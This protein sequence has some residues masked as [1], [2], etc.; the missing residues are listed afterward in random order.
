MEGRWLMTDGLARVNTK[1]WT[2]FQR[3]VLWS[4][5]LALAAIGV[6]CHLFLS[7]C[8]P[9][10]ARY[11]G[12]Y[13]GKWIPLTSVNKEIVE[14][15]R[16]IRLGNMPGYTEAYLAKLFIPEDTRIELALQG[17]RGAGFTSRTPT[18][19]FICMVY[20]QK[21]L[22]GLRDLLDKGVISSKRYNELKND[23]DTVARGKVFWN[24]R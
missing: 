20:G 10:D 5:T 24:S 18:A 1:Q 14:I 19:E 17:L 11:V 21:Y 12:A 9:L 15:C 2:R 8:K 23:T 16:H 22:T 6:T 7:N 3:P 4:F 13:D